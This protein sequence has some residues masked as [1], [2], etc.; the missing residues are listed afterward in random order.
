MS[1]SNNSDWEMDKEVEEE[2]RSKMTEEEIIGMYG[3]GG[4]KEERMPLVESWFP[5]ESEWGGKT[6][7]TEKQPELI[8]LAEN[9]PNAFP[10][11][12]PVEPLLQSFID[13]YEMRLTSI[14]GVSRDQHMRVLRGLFGGGTQGEGDNPSALQIA[15]SA[16]NNEDED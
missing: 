1:K 4:S 16:G 14:E 9:L 10:T 3:S 7:F 15:L 13:K 11:L 6:N 8:T 2:L 12:K 5:N